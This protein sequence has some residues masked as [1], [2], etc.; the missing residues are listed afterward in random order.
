MNLRWHFLERW[1]D[2]GLLIL[3][4]GV[5][6]VFLGI[7]GLPLLSDGA[8]GWTR[9]GRAV[10]CLGFSGGYL[11]WGMAAMLAMTLG[12]ACLILGFCHRPAALALTLTMGV[13]SIWRYHPFGGFE[14][15]AYPLTMTVVCVSL[16]ILGPGKY[17]LDKN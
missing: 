16:F 14:S 10:S 15:A 12:G 11:W 13:A 8:P 6:A 9:V 1:Q 7:H 17:A 3:R 2:A 4:A 5:G